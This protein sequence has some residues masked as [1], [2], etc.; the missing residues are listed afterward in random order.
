MFWSN[1]LLCLSSLWHLG[2]CT[3]TYFKSATSPLIRF[4]LLL[5]GG[6]NIRKVLGNLWSV[7][8]YLL[9]I[10]FGSSLCNLEI[11]MWMTLD[12]VAVQL[13]TSARSCTYRDT[14]GCVCWC[15][16]Q[17]T[18]HTCSQT[19]TTSSWHEISEGHFVLH[20][21]IMTH[22]CR[23]S[24]DGMFIHELDHKATFTCEHT[25]T[26]IYEHRPLH[27]FLSSSP[28]ASHITALP[29]NHQESAPTGE[30]IIS[31]ALCHYNR[32]TDNKTLE[33]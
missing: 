9:L 13:I 18:R 10:F 22:H 6:I 4:F 19:H 27:I 29:P 25:H 7:C 20:Q 16:R 32:S 15:L 14:T 5:G 24:Y 28:S 33:Y 11:K 1:F 3:P 2:A 31:S 21:Q 23:V 12:A 17:S 26:H 30:I 8:F